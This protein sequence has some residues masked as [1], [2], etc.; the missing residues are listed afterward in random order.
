MPAVAELVNRTSITT[1][2]RN[3]DSATARQ[4]LIAESFDEFELAVMNDVAAEPVQRR[5]AVGVER[6]GAQRTVKILDRQAGGDDRRA[7][8]LAG[9]MDRFQGHFRRFVAID[10]IRL[11]QM[12]ESLACSDRR[13]AFGLV[14]FSSNSLSPVSNASEGRPP[15]VTKQ[16]S[17]RFSAPADSMKP[18]SMQPSGTISFASMPTATMSL[19]NWPAFGLRRAAE[20]DQIGM[21]GL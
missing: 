17:F 5:V 6:P 12:A 10:R 7:I 16:R 11:R 15:N 1:L 9:A 21:R 4:L 20:I 2:G 13:I 3:H 19:A 18:C 14:C 8:F